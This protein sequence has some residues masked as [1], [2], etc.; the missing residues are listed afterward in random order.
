MFKPINNGI[1]VYFVS[2]IYSLMEIEMEGPNGWCTHMP[3]ARNIL[4]TFTFYHLLM[5]AFIILVF[6]QLFHRKDIWMIIMYTTLFFFIE[7]VMWFMFNPY[8]TIKKYSKENI[9]W[10]T[11]W[12]FGQPIENYICYLVLII[13]YIKTK[14]KKEHM[15]SV[16]NIGILMAIGISL[17]PL[18]HYFYFKIRQ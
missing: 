15:N 16:I 4:A 12:I 14:Y 11:R 2:I 3:T 10:H 5:M 9:H 17:A 13:T 1:F 18:Y 6:F 8:Y 7:D